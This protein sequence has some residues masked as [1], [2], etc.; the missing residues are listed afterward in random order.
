MSIFNPE[1]RERPESNWEK[2]HY[3]S[4][5][6]EKMRKALADRKDVFPDIVLCPNSSCGNA[7]K[8]EMHQGEV[9]CYCTNCGWRNVIQKT[10]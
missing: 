7:L 3:S 6:E 9:L 5:S 4:N 8:I 10:K 1:N 2:N